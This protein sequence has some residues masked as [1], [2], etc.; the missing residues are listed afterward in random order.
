MD[1]ILVINKPKDITSFDCIRTIR[2]T[3]HIDKIG[4]AGTLDPLATGVLV[5]LL[6]EATK[7]SNY[8]MSEEKIYE[9]DVLFG[10]CTDTEDVTGKV[11]L[12]EE[13]LKLDNQTI[14]NM[15]LDFKGV[16][17]QIPPMYSAI[18]VNGKKLYEYA[19]SGIEIE[20]KEREIEVFEIERISDIKVIDNHQTCK[21]RARVSKGTYIRTLC[22]QLGE[23]LNVLATMASLN[24][25]Q[26]GNLT[27]DNSYTLSD[28]INGDYKLI[29]LVS[30]TKCFT[31]IEV[32]DYLF[33]KVYHGMKIAFKDLSVSDNLI[34]F[35]RCGKLVGIYSRSDVCY[36]AERVWN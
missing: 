32:D 10:L 29:D 26:S 15:L 27:L 31:Q 28:V 4:H 19:R 6:G 17:K 23:R 20:R 30:A 11:L 7:L 35:T 12:E 1:G 21:F 8:L 9:F 5:I 14:D 16:I 34:F 25:I 13:C 33:H 18:K 24:R 36:K 22:T 3:L 2:R